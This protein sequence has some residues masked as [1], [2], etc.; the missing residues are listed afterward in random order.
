MVMLDEA[1]DPAR[2]LQVLNNIEREQVSL[3]A[4]AYYTSSVYSR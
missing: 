4:L 2:V 1:V 3:S